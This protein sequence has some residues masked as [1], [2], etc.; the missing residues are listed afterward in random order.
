VNDYRAIEAYPE[1]LSGAATLEWENPPTRN[2]ARH[3]ACSAAELA[4]AQGA[5]GGPVT[6]EALRRGL[7]RALARGIT[8]ARAAAAALRARPRSAQV[9]G[10]FRAA[11]GLLP[12][13]V[14]SWRT[15]SA[16]WVDLGDLVA[17]RIEAAA[18]I[19]DDGSLRYFCWGSAAHCPG[20]ADPTRYR[21]C[22]SIGRSLMCIGRRFWKW[23]RA[24][25]FNFMAGTLVHEALHI[26]FET[27]RHGPKR[28]RNANCY[29]FFMM[30]FNHQGLPP[31]LRS[32]CDDPG[33][34]GILEA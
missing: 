11:F 16:K 17:L 23:L 5:F 20:C 31:H 7:N 8:M 6:S 12:S 29:V 34:A 1:Y 3:F 21:A 32:R 26:Y 30:R 28:F 13:V 22:M 27:V 24:R 9:N 4:Q 19:L 25:R 15:S 33:A 14:P 2:R 18:R 10:L